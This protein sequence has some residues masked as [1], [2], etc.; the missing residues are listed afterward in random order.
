MPKPSFWKPPIPLSPAEERIIAT[1]RHGRIFAVLRQERHEILSDDFQTLLMTKL[2]T[3]NSKGR[4]P[5]HPAQLAMAT[6]L[7]AYTGISDAAVIEALALDPRWQMCVD[8]L[9]CTTPPFAKTTLVRFRAALRGARLDTVL[10]QNA[11]EALAGAGFGGKQLAGR[12]DGSLVWQKTAVS[13]VAVA[14]VGC[15]AVASSR[16]QESWYPER[17]SD[18]DTFTARSGNRELRIRLACI[19]APEA[20]QPFGQQARQKLKALLE[21]DGRI[22]I[23]ETDSDRYGRKV[24]EVF[25]DQPNTET[26]IFVQ[27]E[28]VKAGLALPYERYKHNCPNWDTIFAAG[29]EAKQRRVGVWSLPH[30]ET[31]WDYRRRMRN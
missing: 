17:V 5:A 20:Q 9:G 22:V 1:L 23:N 11:T 8:C 27:E 2:Y 18:G 29:Q 25:N 15:D 4:P 31:P 3:N 19:D 12:F 16:I 7:Q 6:V 24:A 26:D 14:L 10:I 30:L 28:L 13:L 21:L